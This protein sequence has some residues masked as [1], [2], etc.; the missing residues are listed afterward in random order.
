[1]KNS[2]KTLVFSTLGVVAMFLILV[3]VNIIGNY[4]KARVDLTADHQFTLSDGTKKILKRLDTPV[5]IRLYVT[6]D[7]SEMPVAL[8]N[9]AREVEDLLS[10]YQ[11]A[12]KPNIIVKKLD[13]EPD[14]DAEDSANLDGVEGKPV[15]QDGDKIYLGLSV[16]MLD[17]KVAIPFLSPDREPLLE[18]DISRAITQVLSDK[19]AV[20]GIMSPLP[21]AGQPMNPEMMASGQQGPPPWTIYSELQQDFDVKDVPMTADKIPDDV[22]VLLVEQPKEITD[23]AQYAIDQFVLRGGK[24]IACVDPLCALDRQGGGMMG[25]VPSISTLPRLFKAWGIS[26]GTDKVVAD[27]DYMAQTRNGNAPA[28]LDLSEGAFNKDDLLT[29]NADNMLL[30]FAGAFTGTPVA[31]LTETVLIKSSKNSELVDGMMAQMSSDDVI[32]N[33]QASGT[34][35]PLA[36]RLTGKFKTAFPDGK[37]GETKAPEGKDGKPAADG[38]LKESAQD[39][40]VI[41]IGDAD[42]MQDPVAVQQVQNPFGQRMV[43]PANGNLNFIQSAVE[44]MTGDSDLISMRSRASVSRPFVLVKQMQAAAQAKYQ[45]K[46][47]ELEADLTEAEQ[48]LNSIQTT[49]TDGGQKFILS[50]EQQQ[51]LTNFRKKEAEVK[52]QLKDVRRSLAQDIDSLETRLKWINIGLMPLLVTIVSLV[53]FLIKRQRAA[54]R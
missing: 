18:Y 20:V 15:S 21:M 19:K 10:S 39:S 26:F 50:P 14:S 34:Q 29:A 9:Y 12:G 53:F 23:A 54:A 5:Q 22:Q 2:Y 8:R 47:Q 48:K 28:V 16:S 13:P 33:F 41:L 42:F 7:E 36:I 6:Q 4:A 24:L 46:I 40:T 3:A 27:M 52:K 1:M 49:K 17:K 38:S 51:E 45:T 25:G 43:M 35:Y 31:G 32:K 30:A 11:Q 44:Q 37:P